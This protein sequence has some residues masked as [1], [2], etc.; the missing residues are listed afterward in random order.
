M[1]E[2]RHL[3]RDERDRIAVLLA[4]GQSLCV[5]AADLGRAKSTIAREIAR[6]ACPSGRYAPLVA[7]GTYIKRR[8]RPAVLEVNVRLS[9]FVTDRLAEGWAPEQ[10]AGWLRAGNERGLGAVTGET[11][12]RFIYRASQQ[13]AELWRYLARRHKRRR[14]F[15]ARP[16]RDTIRNR[17]SIHDRPDEV[18]HRQEAGHWEG[19]LIICKR[20]RPVLVLHERKTRVTLAARMAGKSAGETIATMLAIFGRVEPNLRKSITFDNDTAFAEHQ[21]LQSMR[22]MTTW[23]CDAY[24]S[25]QKGGIENANGRLR[26]WLPRSI[27][28]DAIP[29]A[30]LQEIIMTYNLTPRKCLAFQTPL[31]ALLAETGKSL[32][33]RFA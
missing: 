14:P 33:I 21:L 1:A 7:D 15:K 19:D 6:N 8:Q 3:S 22:N 25:W 10:I 23:F 9:A 20:T 26:R 27:D 32:Q 4:A 2:Y 5:I 28:I 16:S 13:A 31:Q 11:I 24:A 12:Y 18:A 17:V 30:D 29:D